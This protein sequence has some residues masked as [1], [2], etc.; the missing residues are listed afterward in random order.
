M[1]INVMIIEFCFD[2]RFVEIAKTTFVWPSYNKQQ[3][4]FAH[5]HKTS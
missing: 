3:F 4:S 2:E 1:F 5:T